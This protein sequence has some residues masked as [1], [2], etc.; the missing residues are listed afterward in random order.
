[1]STT[2]SYA[3]VF[4]PLAAGGSECVL[5]EPVRQRVRHVAPPTSDGGSDSEAM[6]VV[7]NV[8]NAKRAAKRARESDSPPA[9]PP[10]PAA[11]RSYSSA[12][13]SAPKPHQI[14][15]KPVLLG[16]STTSALKAS[17]HIDLPKKVFRIGNIDATFDDSAISAHLKSLGVN[18]FSCF[19]RTSVRLRLKQNKAFR[20][21]ILAADS[22][23]LQSPE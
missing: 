18:C 13:A 11:M 15:I 4:P 10:A 9:P 14:A 19:E 8:R 22:A 12:A 16:N 2:S 21:C 20:V 6:D 23:K 7:R 5:N 17:K 3:N 1:M